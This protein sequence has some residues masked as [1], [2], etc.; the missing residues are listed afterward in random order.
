[1]Y[2]TG[3]SVGLDGA[4]AW[5]GW[6]VGVGFSIT[7]QGELAIAP[8]DAVSAVDPV[9]DPN[10][11]TTITTGH[12]LSGGWSCSPLARVR[13]VLMMLAMNC[14]QHVVG[15]LGQFRVCSI[16]GGRP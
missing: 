8:Y 6:R 7:S 2:P 4:S 14:S 12:S 11:G 5:T 9:C 16:A 15:P 13:E 1:M 3:N 10:A